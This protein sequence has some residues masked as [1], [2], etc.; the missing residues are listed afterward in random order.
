MG[1]HRKTQ[2]CDSLRALIL[3]ASSAAIGTWCADAGAAAVTE[4]DNAATPEDTEV[5]V[6]V[7]ANDFDD[8][9]CSGGSCTNLVDIANFTQ[10]ANGSVSIDRNR[11]PQPDTVIYTPDPDFVGTDTF[12]YVAFDLNRDRSAPT[13]VTI[14][15]TPVNDAPRAADDEVETR[16]GNAV[17]I[18]VLEND[19]D[20]DGDT[21]TVTSLTQPD[22]GTVALAGSGVTY[23][24]NPGSAA[25]TTLPTGPATASRHRSPRP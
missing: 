1:S 2:R 23:T 4:P 6:P 13:T 3:T 10:P 18:A 7:L 24:P 15:V 11:R 16:R 8:A 17:T 22:N 9:S 20:V 19:T 21:L 12:T 14:T 5:A 25:P